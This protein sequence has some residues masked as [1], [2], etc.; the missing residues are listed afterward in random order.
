MTSNRIPLDKNLCD[1]IDS[2]LNDERTAVSDLALLAANIKNEYMTAGTGRYDKEFTKFWSD[3]EMDRRFK[4]LSNFGK[5]ASAGEG[6]NKV[7][8]QFQK[9]KK[10]LPVSLQ[11]LYEFSKLSAEEMDLCL[12]DT[13]YRTELT[14]D[15]EKWKRK[16]KKPTPLITPGT[17]GREIANWRERWRNPKAKST[18]KRTITLAEIKIHSSL[19]TF[20]SGKHSGVMKKEDLMTISNAIRETI[21]KLDTKLIRIDLNDEKLAANYEKREAAAAAAAVKAAEAQSK[22]KTTRKKA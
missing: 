6:I 10:K 4:S 18:D 1:Q 19:L 20:K 14:S 2:L 13:F 17:S 16:G 22:K 11:G 12:Q 8:A 3:F 21:A 15:P 5:Y 9:Y 7:L